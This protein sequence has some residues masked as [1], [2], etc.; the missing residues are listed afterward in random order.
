MIDY[1]L[2]E[3]ILFHKEDGY[4]EYGD[5]IDNKT[6]ILFSKARVDKVKLLFR[7]K[8]VGD[9]PFYN[10]ELLCPKCGIFHVRELSRFDLYKVVSDIR[11]QSNKKTLCKKC[12]MDILEKQSIYEKEIKSKRLLDIQ[13]NTKIYIEQFLDPERSWKKGI[14]N[15][16]KI[17]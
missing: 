15:Y 12:N 10:V 14:S 7:K 4:I 3:T 13:N 9:K 5:F 17:K 8:K 6:L 1:H 2:F 16:V 11:T